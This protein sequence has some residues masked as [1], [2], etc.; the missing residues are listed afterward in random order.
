MS[1]SSQERSEDRKR[2]AICS[3]NK[4]I[5]KDVWEEAMRLTKQTS[6]TRGQ[7]PDSH[8]PR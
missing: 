5:S 7:N 8:N 4:G 2:K 3:G 6:E 1:Q